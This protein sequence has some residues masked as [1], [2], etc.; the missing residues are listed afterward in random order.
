MANVVNLGQGDPRG[1]LG[2]ELVHQRNHRLRHL[3]GVTIRGLIDPNRDGGVAIDIHALAGKGVK[4]IGGLTHIGQPQ[5]VPLGRLTHNQ[6]V[7]LFDRNQVAVVLHQ[8]R[9][10]EELIASRRRAAHK[11]P[12]RH[13]VL[14][15][16]GVDHVIG[17]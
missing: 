12:N 17:R 3:Q 2:S 10:G 14:T 13:R 1:H 11:T 8:D 9:V 6:F 7:Q 15:L 16:N 5:Q 4:A